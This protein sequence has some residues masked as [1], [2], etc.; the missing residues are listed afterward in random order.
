[1]VN[2]DTQAKTVNIKSGTLKTGKKIIKILLSAPQLSTENSFDAEA[3]KPKEEIS[4]A[5][6]GKISTEI[7]ANSL[8]VLKLK[9][10]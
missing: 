2:T 5:K 10:I 8:M 1:M 9:I 3:I 6:N 4:E 7:P